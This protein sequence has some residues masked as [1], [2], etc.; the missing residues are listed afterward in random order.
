VD[1]TDLL[2]LLRLQ[3]AC[4]HQLSL[5]P[6]VF[7]VFQASFHVKA[8]VFMLFTPQSVIPSKQRCP[9]PGSGI[10]GAR[11]PA[12]KWNRRTLPSH[13]PNFGLFVGVRFSCFVRNK[14]NL[15]TF[16]GTEKGVKAIPKTLRIFLVPK[17]FPACFILKGWKSLFVAEKYGDS[18]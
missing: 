7:N 2:Y 8:R 5:P 10:I 4:I 3:A 15:A 14:P 12:V 11:Q 13:V 17:N 6:C 9:L 18:I 1:H 16:S